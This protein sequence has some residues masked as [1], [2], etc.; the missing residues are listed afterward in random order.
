MKHF[1]LIGDP[2]AHSLSPLIYRFLFEEYG[3]EADFALLQIPRGSVADVLEH[4]LDGFACT[5]P[6]KEAIIAH[7]AAISDE[8]AAMNSVNIVKRTENGL[9]GHSTDGEGLRLAL[10][11]KTA[12]TCR[13]IFILGSG[14]AA[15]SA[16]FALMKDNRVTVFARNSEA[17]EKLTQSLGVNALPIEEME[18]RMDKCDIF[19]NATPQGMKGKGEFESLEFIGK[20]RSDAALCDMVYNPRDTRLL[21]AAEGR[22]LVTIEGIDMLV[23]QAYAAFDIWFGIK[24]DAALLKERL[25][26]KI[27][28]ELMERGK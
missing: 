16:V 7:L 28:Q 12:V 13:N 6:H 24:P 19:I 20:M 18:S 10:G 3:I 26:S 22:G 14:G 11:A 5:M 9:E 2:V 23:M 1:A 15:R 8:A 25:Y 21:Q 17:R 4:D 27:E